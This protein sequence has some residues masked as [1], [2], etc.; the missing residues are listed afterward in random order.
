MTRRAGVVLLLAFVA[1]FLALNA[2]AYRGY[3]QDDE[4]DNISWT[5]WLPFSDFAQ[6]VATPLTFQN[7]FRPVGHFYFHAIEAV[8]GLDFPVYVAVLQALHVLNVWLLWGVMRRMGAAAPGAALACCFFG[9]HMALFDDFWKPMYVFD[10]LCATFCLASVAAWLRGRWV[11][12]LAAFWL[13]Y[14]CKELAVMLPAVLAV[15]EWW[16]GKRRW[17]LLIP[18][19]AV[20]L[21][22]GLQGLLRNAAANNDYTFR[23]TLTAIGKTLPFYAGRVFLIP[24]AGVAVAALAA[25]VRV[26]RVWFGLSM[27]ALFF[28]PLLFLPGRLFSAYCY[29]PFTGLAVA[30]SGVNAP[31]LAVAIA[32][33]M[34]MNIREMRVRS[35]ETLL[36]DGQ[37]QTWMTGVQQFAATGQQVDGFVFSG[38]PTG[39][40]RWGVEGAIKYWFPKA[41]VKWIEEPGAREWMTGKRVASIEWDWVQRRVKVEAAH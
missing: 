33:W 3:F 21:N 23:F 24:W 9:L 10:V 32:L 25:V 13:A 7:N 36:Q 11:W 28:F 20:S 17:K 4:I 1:V 38:E 37:I 40:E 5:R 6:G 15:W 41:Q 2:G 31:A 39:F 22:F 19:V 26:R 27:M 18:F 8:A 14:K 16:F 12:S 30:L 29:L 35:R 34:P